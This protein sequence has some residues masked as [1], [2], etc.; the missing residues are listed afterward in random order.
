MRELAR[1]VF[2][3]S[4]LGAGQAFSARLPTSLGPDDIDTLVTR[5]GFGSITKAMRS[6]EAYPSFP[7]L[8]IGVEICAIPAGG[9]DTLGAGNGSLPSLLPIPRL[10][11]VK[12]LVE[13]GELSFSFFPA[14]LEGTLGTYGGTLKWEIFTEAEDWIAMAGYAGYTYATGFRGSYSS[15]TFEMGALI[16]RDFVRLK[17]YLGLAL[18]TA[19]GSVA[20][21]FTAGPPESSRRFGIHTFAG[22]EV[23]LPV[24]FVAQLDLFNLE[25]A[26]SLAVGAKF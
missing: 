19:K 18:M 6:A 5:L 8:R 16:S 15:G 2:L 3:L 23:E 9:L 12:G 11:L 7:G 24:N 17:P 1:F 13:G 26:G 21:P 4:L 20:P 14:E 25:L 10:H 22:L